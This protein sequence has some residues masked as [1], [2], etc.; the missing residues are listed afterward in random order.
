VP[1]QSRWLVRSG[2]LWFV[3][4][5]AAGLAAAVGPGTPFALPLPTVLHLYTVGWITQLILGV[6]FWMFPRAS[7]P[8]PG[9]TSE[10]TAA[11][12]TALAERAPGG[13]EGL[14]SLAYALLNAGLV[15]RVLGEPGGAPGSGSMLVLAGLAQWCAALCAAVVLWPRVRGVD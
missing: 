4:A 10:A 11:P 9:T 5:T 2:L 8:R 6:A 12:A 7:K 3:A 1:R 13:P 14:M 15:L